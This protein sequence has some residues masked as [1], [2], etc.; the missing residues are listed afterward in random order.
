MEAAQ[1]DRL[2]PDL[3]AAIRSE[4]SKRNVILAP[5]WRPPLP[6]ASSRRG[7]DTGKG[8]QTHQLPTQRGP[9][10]GLGTSGQ[11]RDKGWTLPRVGR[12]SPT[13]VRR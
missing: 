8:I 5:S 6:G 7:E 9:R 13:K 12:I 4:V 10:D 2:W 11:G 3:E 1:Q